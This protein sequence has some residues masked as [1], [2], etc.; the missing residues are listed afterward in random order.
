MLLEIAVGKRP[1]QIGQSLVILF[2]M[3]ANVRGVVCRLKSF[4]ADLKG[5]KQSVE[6]ISQSLMSQ[7]GSHGDTFEGECVGHGIAGPMR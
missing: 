3:R 1:R 4:C 6:A 2:N 5:I 7:F